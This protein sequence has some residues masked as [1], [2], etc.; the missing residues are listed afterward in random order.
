M[1]S[2]STAMVFGVI[3]ASI[4]ARSLNA[5]WTKPGSSGSKPCLILS[6]PVAVSVAIVRPWKEFFAVMIS[7]R[8]E[9]CP[10]LRASLISASLASAPLL[11]KKTLPGPVSS[12]IR[13]ASRPCHS[14]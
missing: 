6:C 14:L 3:A 11:Q 12:T 9:S 7:K 4:A 1:P 2:I 8:P 10:A 5:T 13:C